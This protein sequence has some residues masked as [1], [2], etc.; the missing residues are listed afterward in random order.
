MSCWSFGHFTWYLNVAAPAPLSDS[1][2]YWAHFGSFVGLARDFGSTYFPGIT[3]TRSLLCERL[4]AVWMLLK[5]Q[6]LKKARFWRFS[7]RALRADSFRRPREG[8]RTQP[9]PWALLMDL[10]AF[11]S[12]P[13]WHTTRVS[14]R[15]LARSAAASVRG[16]GTL[17]PAAGLTLLSGAGSGQ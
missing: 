2:L 7:L 6:R 4:T 5:A 3:I 11:F 10:I 14:P 13:R 17:P 9:L 8:R 12:E 15:D 1:S 16:F